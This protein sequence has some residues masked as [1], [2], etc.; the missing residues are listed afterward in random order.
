MSKS[1]TLVFKLLVR[2]SFFSIK[3]KKLQYVILYYAV[4]STVKKT[5]SPGF[6][7][8]WHLQIN[9]V[10]YAKNEEQNHKTKT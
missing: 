10:F 4:P 8:G 1:V 6:H 9:L 2:I 7:Y 5:K 3:I